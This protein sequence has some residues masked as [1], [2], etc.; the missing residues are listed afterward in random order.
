MADI[1]SNRDK[2]NDLDRKVL[3][4]KWAV[5]GAIGHS[6]APEIFEGNDVYDWLWRI[7]VLKAEVI[8]FIEIAHHIGE[9]E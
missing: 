6:V 9:E 1:P 4:D 2:M 5:I 7:E 8:S 3:T